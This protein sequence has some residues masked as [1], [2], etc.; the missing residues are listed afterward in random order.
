L[1]RSADQSLPQNPILLSEILDNIPLLPIHPAGEEHDQNRSGP[2]SIM[3][4]V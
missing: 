1:Q 4:R 2:A 3:C